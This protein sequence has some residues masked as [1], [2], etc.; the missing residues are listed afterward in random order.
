MATIRP[1]PS[2]PLLYQSSR[3][4]YG[5]MNMS[6][7]GFCLRSKTHEP[8]MG[9]ERICEVGCP[10]P[11]WFGTH[12]T[13]NT[14]ENTLYEPTTHVQLNFSLFQDG[15]PKT[16]SSDQFDEIMSLF[17]HCT[18][19]RDNALDSRAYFIL[20]YLVTNNVFVVR[21]D[22]GPLDQRGWTYVRHT[23]RHRVGMHITNDHHMRNKAISRNKIG[24]SFEFLHC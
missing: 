17:A 1:H 11:L 5:S 6:T 15:Q 20:S 10:S 13:T 4:N 24:T 3:W 7:C 16:P 21:I 14:A 12:P 23:W 9:Q 8:N 18:S 19:E 2:T 22:D